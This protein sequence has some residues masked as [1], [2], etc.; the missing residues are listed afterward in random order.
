VPSL[1]ELLTAEVGDLRRVAKVGE[2]S[3]GEAFKLGATVFKIIPIEGS[4]HVNG[5]PQKKAADLTGEALVSLTLSGLRNDRDQGECSDYRRR[6][7][8]G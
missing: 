5:F 3:Y 8:G 7:G 4:Q 2:G 1:E 6:G